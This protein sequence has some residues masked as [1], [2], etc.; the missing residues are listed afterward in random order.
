MLAY[1]ADGDADTTQT[2]V[3]IYPVE[4]KAICGFFAFR[5]AVELVAVDVDIP[6]L[7]VGGFCR[8][9]FHAQI[10]FAAPAFVDWGI[11]RKSVV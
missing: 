5:G 3:L 6:Q 4:R 9:G 11:D 2:H 7:A 1:R 10:A 8:A